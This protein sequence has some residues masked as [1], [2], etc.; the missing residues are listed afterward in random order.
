V[1]NA[2]AQRDRAQ[3]ELRRGCEETNSPEMSA[4][5]PKVGDVKVTEARLRE[6]AVAKALFEKMT[7]AAVKRINGMSQDEMKQWG[8]ALKGSKATPEA[9]CPSLEIENTAAELLLLSD[10]PAHA[11]E[12]G[13]STTPARTSAQLEASRECNHEKEEKRSINLP[14]G[15]EQ[16]PRQCTDFPTLGETH[17]S[18][19]QCK[20]T[21]PPSEEGTEDLAS[22][23]LPDGPSSK[24]ESAS[25][26]TRG[27]V[28][29]LEEARR[30]R[31]EKFEHSIG[32]EHWSWCRQTITLLHATEEGGPVKL[33]ALFHWKRQMSLVTHLAARFAGLKGEEAKKI[34]VN[35]IIHGEVTS[36]C[37]SWVP[38]EDWRGEKTYLKARGVD[39]IAVLPGKKHDQEDLK[40]FPQLVAA[41]D[42]QVESHGQIQLMIALDN[43]R[44]MP[45]RQVIEPAGSPDRYDLDDMKF[46]ART[47]LERDWFCWMRWTLPR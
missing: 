25:R 43:W 45:V 10:A 32:L 34:K 22:A 46:L 19:N 4:H 21:V 14:P 26:T 16:V 27:E 5:N 36:T 18:V 1:R 23:A 3:A 39:Y 15:F 2:H 35:T 9:P 11:A 41:R 40:C 38:L 20:E 47:H 44:Y 29:S 7:V 24:K 12:P 6:G 8:Q 28:M 13:D 30:L 31:E 37:A 17:P 33:N 42:E